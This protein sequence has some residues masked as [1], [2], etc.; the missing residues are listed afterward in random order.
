MNKTTAIIM[1]A[2]QGKRMNSQVAKQFLLL[3][4]KPVLYY[5]LKAFEESRIDDII[6][7]TGEDQIEYCQKQIV[8]EYN[9]RKVTKIIE[10]GKERY[11][12]VYQGLKNIEESDYVLIHDGARP[13]I[14]PELINTVIDQ[15]ATWKACLIGNPVKET[16]K[17]VN[18]N[19]IITDTPDRSTLW[20][21]Q[22]PQAFEYKLIKNAYDRLYQEEEFIRKGITD[23][24]MVWETYHGQPVK[25]LFGDYDNVKITT[26]EDILIADGILSKLLC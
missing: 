5:S 10:G 16:I 1:A 18:Q 26:P 12:S 3:K 9:I 2:G 23:D 20:A 19:G 21:A 7:V 25:M 14:T 13:C 24:A 17:V 11:D 22:T 15:V 6:L 8:D 4:D